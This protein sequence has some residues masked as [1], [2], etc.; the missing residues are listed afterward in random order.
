MTPDVGIDVD[1]AAEAADATDTLVLV[2]GRGAARVHPRIPPTQ[3]RALQVVESRAPITLGGLSQALGMLASS[4]SRLCD[5]LQ[6]AGLLVR[7]PVASDRRTVELSLTADGARLLERLRAARRADLGEVLGRM[8][9]LD[10][11]ALLRGLRAFDAA[12]RD[13]LAAHDSDHESDSESDPGTGRGAE[14][15]G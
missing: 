15:A 7:H 9:E 3:L 8:T 10:R 14:I 13:G 5:R 2:H 4:A 12:V 11:N 1:T 6:A